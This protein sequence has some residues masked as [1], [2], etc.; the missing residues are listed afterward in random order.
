MVGKI[1]KATKS[2]GRYHIGINMQNNEG[3]II[4]AER[5]SDGQ[6]VY[7]DAQI[8]AF[9]KLEEYTERG[10]EYFEVL[11]VDKLILRLDLFKKIVRLL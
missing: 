2:T 4:T 5:L 3:H 1:E 8:S 11:K 9:L 10:V 6:M 7:Y